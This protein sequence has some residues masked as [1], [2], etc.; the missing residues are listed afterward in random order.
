MCVKSASACTH[1]CLC[2]FKLEHHTR[3]LQRT[4]K[5]RRTCTPP[6][7]RKQAVVF[8]LFPPSGSLV[9]SLLESLTC[10]VSVLLAKL[11]EVAQKYVFR[12]HQC[13]PIPGTHREPHHL[14]VIQH[15]GSAHPFLFTSVPSGTTSQYMSICTGK[16]THTFWDRSPGQIVRPLVRVV[17]GPGAITCSFWH[18][19]YFLIQGGFLPEI[20]TWAVDRPRTL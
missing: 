7:A 13:C 18:M 2:V 10:C 5:L 20:K 14:A 12:R 1:A 11:F 19:V 4:L 3:S 8:A 17:V 15:P 6:F 16:P 9:H